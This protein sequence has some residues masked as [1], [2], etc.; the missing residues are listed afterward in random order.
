MGRNY[1][2]N[3]LLRGGVEVAIP[4]RDKGIDLIVYLDE[5]TIMQGYSARP[6]QIKAA[7]NS[8]FTIDKK[9]ARYPHLILTYIWHLDT[10]A[11]TVVYGL[12]YKDALAVAARMGY[13]KTVSW[14]QGSYTT[15]RPSAKL[16]ELLH[17]YKMT[18]KE[19]KSA[20]KEF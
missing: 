9:Y 11:K 7:S 16:I 2:I 8:C 17:P 18:S 10:P 5:D 14:E 20:L 1:L 13:T 6:I 3:Q 15:T 4:V 19:W 12:D